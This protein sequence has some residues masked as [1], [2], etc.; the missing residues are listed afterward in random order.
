[1]KLQRSGREVLVPAGESARAFRLPQPWL[2]QPAPD[3]AR[4]CGVGVRQLERKFFAAYGQSL[5]DSRRMA[6]YERALGM[7]IADPM[8]RHGVLTRVA[9]DAGYHD[10]AHMVRDFVHYLGLP[11]GGLQTD[12]SAGTLRLL[13]YDSA[14][15]AV[16][17]A[18]R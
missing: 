15:R 11:P 10:Q 12:E 16:L 18:G 7:L 4:Q 2:F 17:L 1:L 13:R 9:M 5:R 8:R 3:I 6:R 14:S